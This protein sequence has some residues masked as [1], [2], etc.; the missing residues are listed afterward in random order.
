MPDLS[1]TQ[2]DADKILNVIQANHIY[3]PQ[4]FVPFQT[5]KALGYIPKTHLE[6]YLD[7]GLFEYD[8]L[9]N[10]LAFA[11]NVQGFNAKSEAI[12]TATAALI[13]KGLIKTSANRISRNVLSGMMRGLKTRNLKST[14]LIIVIT[15]LWQMAF[16]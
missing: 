7:T 16:L 5:E 6:T 15:G 14:G 2:S 9:K 4:D 11:G 3:A 8:D 1:L 12:H 10:I 13:G